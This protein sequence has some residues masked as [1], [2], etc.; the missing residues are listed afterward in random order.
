[1]RLYFRKTQRLTRE[2]DFKA[3]LAHKCLVR[4]GVMRLY[5]A[6]N[7]LGFARFAVSLGR[8]CGKAVDR[9][10]LKRLAREAFRLHQHDLPPG[11]DYLLILS[12]QQP[13]KKKSPA[14]RL[15]GY[16]AFE[17][18]FLDMVKKLSKKDCFQLKKDAP[19]TEPVDIDRL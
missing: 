2:R 17:A 14:A 7:G 10:R 19:D 16:A 5:A 6:P 13:I 11:R 4:Q 3:V 15:F 1:M 12:A 9:N 18:H 8:R